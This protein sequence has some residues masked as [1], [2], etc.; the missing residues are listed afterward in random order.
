[1]GLLQK[2]VETYDAMSGLAGRYEEGKE[3]LAPVGHMVTK[4]QIE[5]TLDADGGF[6]EARAA[7][8]DRKIIIPV[9]EASAG[10]T[11]SPAAHPLCEQ[12]GYLLG[13][14][15]TKKKLYAEQLKAWEESAYSHPKLKAILAYVTSG[16]MQDDLEREGLLKYD[17]DKL[18]NEKDMVCWRVIGLERGSGPVWTDIDLMKAYA[19]YYQA[20]QQ[21]EKQLC[22]LSGER[23]VITQQHMKGV[24]S[25]NG[26]AK[27]IS[28]NDSHNFTYRGR[29]E[30]P[31]EAAS[32]GYIASQ[33]A[34]N[35]LKWLVSN[36]GTV[37]GGRAFVCWNPHGIEMPKHTMPFG[38]RA[39]GAEAIPDYKSYQE[40]LRK[41]LAGYRAVLPQHEQVIIASFDAATT[42]RLAVVYY[43]EL[44]ASDFLQRLAFWDESCC[45]RDNRWG[46]SS[47]P[48]KKIVDT[49]FGTFRGDS[50]K[51]V[52]DDKVL[53]MHMQRL[54]SCRID[55]AALP[56]DI[57]Y[58]IVRKME[59]LQIYPAQGQNSIRDELLFTACAVIRKYH[60]DHAKEEF[61][62][63]LEPA[64]K[65]RSY[66]FGRLLAVME[67]I[68]RDTYDMNEQRETNAIRMQ[69]MFVRRPGYAAKVVM[70]TLKSAYYPRL[71]PGQRVFYDKLIGEIMEQLSEF[72][73]NEYNKPLSET[74]LPGYYLQKNALW[75]KKDQQ[76]TEDE[77]NDA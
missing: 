43:N 13:A 16:A 67:K 69:A 38:Y 42:G 5:I 27:I 66:Q 46:V 24:F 39:S 68:E 63:A 28:A 71:R 70:D 6:V 11:S 33:K 74:Y 47:P 4:A 54:I 48:L 36:Q 50:G 55:Q 59:N 32:I 2:A 29:F 40:E 7:D 62:L 21:Q 31:E 9:T 45:W 18:N 51:M 14:D 34:H 75:A 41:R 15:P 20:N 61:A 72:G 23:A 53:A 25:F 73:E 76:M 8:K 26:N 58:A 19:G 17:G 57:L 64:R 77:E 49:A 37:Q 60:M 22:M 30:E 10:R 35:A 52:T 12:L 56:R 44:Q 1:M 65:D 3:P